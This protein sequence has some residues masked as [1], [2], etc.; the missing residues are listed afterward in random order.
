MADLIDRDKLID[1]IVES[2]PEMD[3]L[4][5]TS[6]LI[7]NYKTSSTTLDNISVLSGSY[8]NRIQTNG[9]TGIIRD[10]SAHNEIAELREMIERLKGKPYYMRIQC[11]N[12]GA[13]LVIESDNH[14]IKCKYC[15]TAYFSGTQLVNDVHTNKEY[16]MHMK[17]NGAWVP[18]A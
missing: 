11:H 8:I 17:V 15:H 6:D 16:K 14:L 5:E 1:H 4:M 9:V 10:D 2:Y 7:S 18:V 13:P 12:C 3:D